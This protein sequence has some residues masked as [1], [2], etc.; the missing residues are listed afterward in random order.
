[1]QLRIEAL[2]KAGIPPIRTVGEP[3]AHGETVTGIQDCGVK[4]PIAAAVAA[5]TAGFAIDVHMANGMM[6]TL[7]LLSI[8]LAAGVVAMTLLVGIIIRDDGA[9]PNEHIKVQPLVTKIPIR[10]LLSF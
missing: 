9:V 10:I 6:L 2:F 1:M 7:G 8:I 4:T 3:G 5:A